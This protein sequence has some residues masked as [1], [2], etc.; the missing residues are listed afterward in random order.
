L[1]E[2][3]IPSKRYPLRSQEVAILFE[4]VTIPFRGAPILFKEIV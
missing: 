3:A 4:E 2:D 1:R